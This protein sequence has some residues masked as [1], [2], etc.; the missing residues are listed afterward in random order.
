MENLEITGDK[1]EKILITFREGIKPPV[2]PPPNL[3]EQEKLTY[4]AY[5]TLLDG[6]LD[7]LFQR[8]NFILVSMAF[9][10]G[11]VAAL[12]TYTNLH[13]SLFLKIFVIFILFAG[14]ALSLIFYKSNE[15]NSTTNIKNLM[16]TITTFERAKGLYALKSQGYRHIKW[17]D[18]FGVVPIT[19]IIPIGFIGF[20][21]LGS[22]AV[23]VF[24]FSCH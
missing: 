8:V 9:L 19:V 3:S 21:V 16:D 4:Q 23:C 10:I 5:M 12:L 15:I 20:W 17:L 18:R 1:V 24:M 6:E 7:R 11:A 2:D 22:I 14:F 13:Q